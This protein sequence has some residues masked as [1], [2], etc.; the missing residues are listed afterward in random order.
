[1][2]RYY[3]DLSEA[4]IAEVMRATPAWSPDGTRIAFLRPV[5]GGKELWLIDANGANEHRM[6]G[7]PLV[8]GNSAVPWNVT[9]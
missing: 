1:M 2:L 7:A 3:E 5:D 8:F 4:Q 9:A 6:P